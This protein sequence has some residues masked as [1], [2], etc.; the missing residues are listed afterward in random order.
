MQLWYGMVFWARPSGH[1]ATDACTSSYASLQN[2]TKLQVING[3][4]PGELWGLT[5]YMHSNA[6]WGGLGQIRA[7]AGK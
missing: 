5:L 2:Q 1:D 4:D 6:T 7:V 3:D